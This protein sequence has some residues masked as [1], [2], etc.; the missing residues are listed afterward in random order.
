MQGIKPTALHGNRPI[1]SQ[2]DTQ[3]PPFTPH[4][5]V[6]YREHLAL[7]AELPVLAMEEI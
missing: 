5:V 4:T 7:V 3:R 1:K 6:T 2:V